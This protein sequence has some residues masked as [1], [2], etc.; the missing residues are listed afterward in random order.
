MVKRKMTK[1]AQMWH[2]I[3]DVVR[4]AK[5]WPFLI[6]QLFWTPDLKHWNRII[7]TAFVFLN[8]LNPEVKIYLLLN[9]HTKLF[10]QDFLPKFGK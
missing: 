8:G 7:V 2:D 1:E 3:Q 10:V 4:D 6:R 5:L 9:R